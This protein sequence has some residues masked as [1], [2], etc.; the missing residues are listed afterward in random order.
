ML[1]AATI[2]GGAAPR[3]FAPCGNYLAGGESRR[4]VEVDRFYDDGAVVWQEQVYLLAREVADAIQP[5]CVV[6]IGTGSGIKLHTAFA[7]HPAA[8]QQTDWHDQRAPLPDG[9][10]Q[11]PFRAVNLEDFRDLESFEASLDPAEPTLFILSDVIEHL[12]DPRPVLRSL[13][14]LLKRHPANRLIISTPDRERVD[15]AGAD[16]IPDNVGHVRQWTLREFGQAL[17]SAGFRVERIGRQ[18]QNR[19]DDLN[20]TLCAEL[21]CTEEHHR[22]MLAEAGLAPPNDH[23]IITTEHARALRTGGI[24]TYIQL[25]EWVTGKP[26]MVLFAGAHGLPEEWRDFCRDQGWLHVADLLGRG[27]ES[28]DAIAEVD[29]DAVLDA[30]TQAVF[31]YD[32]IRLIEYQDYI[33][34]GARVA[35]AKRA[36]LLPP[37]VTV[38]AYVHGNHLHLDRATGTITGDRPLA[39]D[40]RERLCLELA[41][42][43]AYPS[44]Y[45]RDHYVEAGGYRLPREIHLPCPVPL[46]A[47]PVDELARGPVHN[48]VFFGKQIFLKGHDDFVEACLALFDDPAHAEAAGRIKR[49]VLM[50]VNE[51]DERLKALPVALGHGTYSH[52][53]AMAMLHR[54]APN[55]LVVLPYRGDNHPLSVFEVVQHD[56]QLLAY[57]AGGIPEILPEVLHP[58]VLCD[59]GAAPLTAAIARAVVMPHWQRSELVTRAR[60]ELNRKYDALNRRYGEVIEELKQPAPIPPRPASPG[61]VTVVVPNLNGARQHLADVALGLRNS[62]HRPSRVI[63]VDDGSS[64]EGLKLLEEARGRFGDIPAEILR[65]ERNLGLPAARNSALALAET[66]YLFTHDNDDVVVNRFLE[67]ACRILG[68][69]PGV[70]GVTCWARYFDDGTPWQKE[71]HGPGYRPIGADFGHLLRANSVGGAFGVYRVSALREIG[72]WDES[73][74]AMWEDW[75]LAAK[76][77]AAGHDMWVIPRE[78]MLYRVRRNSMLRTY[79]QFPAWMRLADALPGLPRAHRVALLRALWTPSTLEGETLRPVM[80]EARWYAQAWRDADARVRELEAALDAAGGGEVDVP[81]LARELERLRA[82]ERSTT[83]R[84]STALRR[85]VS[86]VPGLRRLLR[87]GARLGWRGLNRLRGR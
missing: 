8:R 31:L 73:S 37:S 13:R 68:E 83:W 79:Q 22:A 7:G 67:I 62:F 57:R 40:A 44:R 87:G 60:Y 78:L 51:P 76:L 19:F 66:P 26:R 53:E 82:I 75:Q 10:A 20:R 55:S 63:L 49:I 6:D 69:N 34:F 2:A 14:R 70:A 15:G 3:R 17:L 5:T 18:P 64:P 52:A 86:A 61:A 29:P 65:H 42:V 56:C 28:R 43:V 80:H 11:P 24:G 35:Q 48:L 72:G 54:L 50:G 41:D 27:T 9:A 38:M 16:G 33:G 71:S 30:A 32:Q 23:L 81:A 58:D 25:A 1:E 59:V 77:I 85:V 47:D 39:S 21:S 45:V 12:Q 46:A 4:V 36:G 74:K 84:A